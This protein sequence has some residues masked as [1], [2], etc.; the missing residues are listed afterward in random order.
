[1]VTKY[2]LPLTTAQ[3]NHLL[4][5]DELDCVMMMTAVYVTHTDVTTSY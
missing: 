3:L 5:I 2:M 1:M 4:G